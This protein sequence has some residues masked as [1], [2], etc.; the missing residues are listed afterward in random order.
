MKHLFCSSAITL[1]SKNCSVIESS[2]QALNSGIIMKPF[3]Y[4]VRPLETNT[5]IW[6]PPIS[7]TQISA[8]QPLSTHFLECVSE[9]FGHKLSSEA[10]CP[11]MTKDL[12]FLKFCNSF[13]AP[14]LISDYKEP[15][16]RQT[17]DTD[18]CHPFILSCSSIHFPPT[19]FKY[20]KN[21][22]LVHGAWNYNRVAKCILYCFYKNIVLYIIEVRLTQKLSALKAM[23]KA[24]C[25]C[26]ALRF[27]FFKE[28]QMAQLRKGKDSLL[29]FPCLYFCWLAPHST[30]QV[31]QLL[32][33]G[34]EFW[35]IGAEYTHENARRHTHSIICGI[36]NRKSAFSPCQLF[37]PQNIQ[38]IGIS[39][40]SNQFTSDSTYFMS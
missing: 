11:A 16:D 31:V 21:L 29:E 28:M 9:S 14:A 37:S 20:L 32:D 6:T 33:E 4:Y 1:I 12:F 13:S 24:R 5:P 18:F 8:L 34:F 30:C 25:E 15:L 23:Q 39:E 10:F 3:N 2:P 19:Q 27:F 40:K 26:T 38:F 35:H 22:L 17:L 36:I 7:A